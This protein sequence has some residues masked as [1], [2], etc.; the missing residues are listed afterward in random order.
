MFLL[1][2]VCMGDWG[3]DNFSHTHTH[4]QKGCAKPLTLVV[5]PA[6]HHHP[7][8]SLAHLCAL[9]WAWF[10]EW[11]LTPYW[12]RERNPENH[13]ETVVKFYGALKGEPEHNKS[14]VH[15]CPDRPF[16]F[17]GLHISILPHS[18]PVSGLL[19]LWLELIKWKCMT[20]WFILINESI[21]ICSCVRLLLTY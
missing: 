19:W 7:Q 13:H 2:S 9:N 16:L 14:P 3:G 4:T 8:H 1:F 20:F 18:N 21:R 6:V 5:Q 17:F 10:S 15:H 11:L 12:E